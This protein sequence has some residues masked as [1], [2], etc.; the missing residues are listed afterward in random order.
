MAPLSDLIDLSVRPSLPMP[1]QRVEERFSAVNRDDQTKTHRHRHEM[2][3]LEAVGMTSSPV[4]GGD[5]AEEAGD[6]ATNQ[7]S[8]RS[9]ARLN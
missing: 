4:K 3:L 8:I 6:I 1:P 7:A 2:P 5:I 9:P